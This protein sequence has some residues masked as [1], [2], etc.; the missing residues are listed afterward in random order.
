[1]TQTLDL[2]LPKMLA[3]AGIRAGSEDAALLE[4][5]GWAGWLGKQLDMP[6][7]D[8]KEVRGILD[9][10]KLEISYEAGDGFSALTEMRSMSSLFKPT[11]ELW[12]LVD[13]EKKQ[14][15]EERVRPGNELIAATIIRAIHS[16][17]QLLETVTDFWR[18]HFVVNRDAVEDVQVSLPTY[19]HEVLR[20]HAFG[21][22]R[23][24]LEAVATSTAMLAY[25]NNASSKASPANENFARELFELHMLGAP[26]YLHGQF[27]KW[28][29]VPGALEGK[30]AGYIDEDVYEAARAFTGWSYESGQWVTEGVTLPRTGEFKYVE[31]WHD[32]YQKRILGVEFESHAP[33]LEEG[34]KVLDMVAF[35]PATAH[36]VCYRICKRFV[37]DNPPPDLV[38]AA[39]EVFKEQQN[40]PDQLAQVF[41]HVLTSAAF[42]NAEGRLQRPLFLM[43][44][45]MRKAGV[46]PQPSRDFPWLL[47]SMGHK[48]YGWQSPAGHPLSSGYWQSPGLLVRRWRGMNDLWQRAILEKPDMNW[49]N[50]T[51]FAAHWSK[52]MA[53]PDAHAEQAAKIL[54][55]E[56]GDAERAISFN[57][58]ERWTVA[59]ALTFL[60]ATPDFQAV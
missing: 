6:S 24:F 21:N 37:S 36:H 44:S 54:A 59:Q 3:R 53:L 48:L 2:A 60:S 22:F 25:L 31:H 39:A 4:K 26:A 15:Y 50:A 56:F 19:E 52:E 41:K 5:D 42:A 46:S 13:W 49:K 45:I 10:A 34:K 1:M 9:S 20:R 7:E 27:G 8:S 30:A 47:A 11:R 58:D 14:S 33:P 40:A 32:P 43:A 55:T 18:D 38:N 28:R 12:H 29:D 51:E 16:D 17:A 35:H 57:K 23:E